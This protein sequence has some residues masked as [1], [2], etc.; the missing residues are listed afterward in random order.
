MAH[1]SANTV[2]PRSPLFR[3][4]YQLRWTDFDLVAANRLLDQ[5]GLVRRDRRG[6]RLLPT[7]EPA[8]LIV[9]TAGES[10]QETDVL[11]LVRE[12]WLKLGIKLYTRSTQRDLLR[13]RVLSG[14]AAM[15]VWSGLDDATP[16]ADHS[17]TEFVPTRE[18]QFQ[19]PRWG[20]HFESRGQAGEAPDLPAASELLSL[21]TAWKLSGSPEERERIW[22][23]VLEINADQ[24]FTIGTVNRSLQ[25]VV[26]SRLLRNVPE[27]ASFAFEPGGFF[28]IYMP[29][30][31][32]F[33][34]ATR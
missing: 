3:P 28:G 20:L 6:I 5:T 4:D 16:T 15:A 11:N 26:V 12:S 25:P 23:R 9:E 32:W 17:P 24:V 29:D 34:Q 2:I 33:E 22:H 1:A 30:T 13:K 14:D 10:T 27:K 7:G 19:W 18:D 8:E 31:F 21:L